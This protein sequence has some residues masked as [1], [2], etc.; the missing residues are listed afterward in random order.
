MRGRFVANPAYG[1][2]DSR[3]AARAVYKLYR[4]PVGGR[5]NRQVIEVEV[6]GYGNA[7]LGGVSIDFF[8]GCI[9]RNGQLGRNAE[10]R[11]SYRC[12]LVVVCCGGDGRSLGFGRGCRVDVEGDSIRQEAVIKCGAY[13]WPYPV[14]VRFND[15]R[16]NGIIFEN[17]GR[18][19][20]VTAYG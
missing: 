12:R 1:V 6:G 2:G 17:Y 11:D 3:C 15:E 20:A 4:G 8:I 18:F 13:T 14:L 16:D 10:A 9:V 19:A 7:V 5:L